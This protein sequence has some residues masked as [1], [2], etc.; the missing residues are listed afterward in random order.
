MKNKIS[1][2]SFLQSSTLA[3]A[4]AA[5]VSAAHAPAQVLPAAGKPS[6]VRL[7]L[8]SYTFR[9]FTR[10]QLIGFMKQLNVLDLNAKDVKDH[11]PMDPTAEAAAMADY[12]ASGIQVH[13]I[14]TVSFAKDED[15]DIRGKFE[16]AKRAGTSKFK[17]VKDAYRYILQVLR[18][19]MYFNPLKVLMPVALF[20]LGLG[21]L[22]G[23]YDLIVHPLL[24]AVNT[25]LIFLT[26]VLIASLALLA[27]LIVRSR[28]DV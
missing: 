14:G 18:M 11:L 20:L 1:R 26:G 12:A 4:S 16:Y 6:P 15:D 2:R 28:G 5:L 7:G 17:F 25:V 8:A 22:K 27:D 21:I 19:V 9:N 23:V 3:A 24:F 13:A 10:A